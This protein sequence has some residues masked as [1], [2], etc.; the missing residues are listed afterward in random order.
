MGKPESSVTDI[1]MTLSV[2]RDMDI[3]TLSDGEKRNVI[4]GVQ[5]AITGILPILITGEV[6]LASVLRSLDKIPDDEAS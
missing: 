1:I 4:A 2:F 6:I 5:K 3:E